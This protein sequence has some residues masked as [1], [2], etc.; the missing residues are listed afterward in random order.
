V[1][2]FT[3][4]SVLRPV[5][6]LALRFST[7]RKISPRPSG[8]AGAEVGDDG[9]AED[10]QVLVILELPAEASARAA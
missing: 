5:S 3:M 2:V 4:P 9:R 1:P 8:V 7:V 6:I 10:Q